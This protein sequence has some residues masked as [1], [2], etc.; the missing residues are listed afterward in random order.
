[1]LP[2][3]FMMKIFIFHLLRIFSQQLGKK[4]KILV[5]VGNGALFWS[6]INAKKNTGA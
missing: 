3:N 4:E 6:Q 1:M 5:G 2:V